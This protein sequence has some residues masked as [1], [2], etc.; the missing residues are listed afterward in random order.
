MGVT[1]PVAERDQGAPGR[2]SAGSATEAALAEEDR[3]VPVQ[4]HSRLRVRP[5][6]QDSTCASTSRP[7]PPALQPAP[8]GRGG[9][10]IKPWTERPLC[11]DDP[12][13]PQ[14]R[15][16]VSA[17]PGPCL[18]FDHTKSTGR[19]TARRDATGAGPNPPRGWPR[20]P[21]HPVCEDGARSGDVFPREV[22]REVPI[23]V[24]LSRASSSIGRAADF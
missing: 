3:P 18:P 2:L 24:P 4:Q 7:A 11:H 17:P 9:A 22:P 15:T 12:V 8:R 14:D 6:A 1:N 20:S 10:P 21:L 13:G 23:K 5:T 16:C 19:L